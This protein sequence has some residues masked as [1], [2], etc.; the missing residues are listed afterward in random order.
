MLKLVVLAALAL[1]ACGLP[2]NLPKP[3]HGETQWAVLVAGSNGYGNY[4]HQSDVCHAYHVL[5]SHGIPD[6]NIIVMMYDDI[7]HSPSNPVKGSIINHVNGP[8]VYEGVPKDYTGKD[9]TPENFL[10]VIQGQKPM[11]GSGKVLKAGPNDHVFIYYSDHGATGLVAFPTGI[12]TVKQLNDALKA[13]HKN[14]QYGELVFYLE[15]CEAG[16]MF[17]G[18]LPN[19]INVFATTAA[20]AV[21][22]SYACYYDSSRNAYLGDHYS[23]NWMEDSDKE[24]L[25]V[26]TLQTQFE[27]V[28][29]LTDDS[30]VMEY[31]QMDISKQVVGDFQG[32]QQPAS[33][34][35][36]PKMPKDTIDAR[37][38]PVAIL[39]HRLEEAATEEE[40]TEVLHELNQ[41]MAKR[42]LIDAVMDQLVFR[43]SSEQRIGSAVLTKSTL[44]LRDLACHERVSTAFHQ[45]CF[46]L[47]ENPYAMKYI[48]YLANMCEL[49]IAAD[50][51]VTEMVGVCTHGE[52]RGAN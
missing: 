48:R 26:E 9:V 45:M 43:V 36:L 37:E 33:K 15:A 38:V 6:S 10:K 22:S 35:I 50:Q 46:N 29:K 14:N 12:L 41:L 51:I 5:K 17:E 27:I 7:A 16:S 44:Q 13:M 40:K 4:R 32:E 8:N 1:I 21:E 34:Q 20:N 2:S 25:E 24:N 3:K 30:H 52:I 18:V 31:G 39:R 42:Q 49:G 23:V 47:N 28:K 11:G 19:N